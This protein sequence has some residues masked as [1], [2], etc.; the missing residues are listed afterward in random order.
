V[1]RVRLSSS[2]QRGNN[3][4]NSYQLNALALTA[5]DALHYVRQDITAA[6]TEDELAN[7]DE[8]GDSITTGP[9]A[10]LQN[11]MRHFFSL[12]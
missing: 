1:L 10:V 3:N 5:A 6:A 7:D 12:T 11:I 8:V 9:N 2:S 4:N